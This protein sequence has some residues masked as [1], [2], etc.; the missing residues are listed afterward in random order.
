MHSE[1]FVC[2]VMGMICIYTVGASVMSSAVLVVNVLHCKAI[3][4][5]SHIHKMGGAPLTKQE[6][7]VHGLHDSCCVK[8]TAASCR[9]KSKAC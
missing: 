1:A 6:E 3:W 5:R 4:Y 8:A 7:V 2:V 9:V